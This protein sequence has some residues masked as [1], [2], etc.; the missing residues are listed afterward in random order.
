MESL[1]GGAPGA[2]EK[3]NRLTSMASAVVTCV[4][5]ETKRE[6]NELP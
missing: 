4:T 6:S 3:S 5:R 1:T 2:R